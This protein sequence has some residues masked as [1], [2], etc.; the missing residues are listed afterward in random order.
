MGA[1]IKDTV[2]DGSKQ[3]Q[4]IILILH[5]RVVTEDSRSVLHYTT[6]PKNILARL[7]NCPFRAIF[8]LF[9]NARGVA[10]GLNLDWLSAN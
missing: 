2:A 9:I 10:S 7:I 6:K 5:G 3:F 4:D 1:I 8:L